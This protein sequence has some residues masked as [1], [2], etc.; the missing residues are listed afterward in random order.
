MTT[1]LFLYSGSLAMGLDIELSASL[2]LYK[3]AT[4][5]NQGRWPLA[6]RTG[7]SSRQKTWGSGLWRD[8][9]RRDCFRTRTFFWMMFE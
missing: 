8:A 1:I 5:Q 2:G 4:G 6:I 3:M 9:P 7:A